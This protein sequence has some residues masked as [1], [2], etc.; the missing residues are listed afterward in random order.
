[1]TLLQ[2]AAS[3]KKERKGGGNTSYI[4]PNVSCSVLGVGISCSKQRLV[5]RIA[6]CW[7]CYCCFLSLHGRSQRQLH[8]VLANGKCWYKPGSNTLK[9][10]FR[11][12]LKKWGEK[13]TALFARSAW[14]RLAVAKSCP[15]MSF[16]GRVSPCYHIPKC[17][18][19]RVWDLLAIDNHITLTPSLLSPLQLIY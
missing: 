19:L 14:S 16:L 2:A 10:H 9:V 17:N 18:I 11:L 7:R 5:K 13:L 6:L 1:M 8:G 12:P 4:S 3:F 15:E